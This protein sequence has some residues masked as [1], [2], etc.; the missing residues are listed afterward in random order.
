MRGW[1][2]PAT[3]VAVRAPRPRGPHMNTWSAHL[4][5]VCND[6]CK[7]GHPGVLTLVRRRDGGCDEGCVFPG[8]PLFARLGTSLIAGSPVPFCCARPLRV[9]PIEDL[10]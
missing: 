4:N 2:G 7:Q 1:R 3:H 9:E 8:H 5:G 10:G 6:V